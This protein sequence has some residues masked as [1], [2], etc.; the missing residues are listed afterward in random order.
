[1]ANWHFAPTECSRENLLAERVSPERIVVTGNTVID[2]LF[3][4]L[5]RID[6]EPARR[7]RIV[8]ELSAVLGFAWATRPFVLITGHRRENFGDGFLQICEALRA[9]ATRYPEVHFVYL[10]P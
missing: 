2:A 9:L 4:V 5:S 7:D 1:V 6:A 10:V 3:W 8:G